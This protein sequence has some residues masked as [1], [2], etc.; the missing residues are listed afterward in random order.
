VEFGSYACS[1]GRYLIV[2]HKLDQ[3][4]H[5][6]SYPKTASFWPTPTR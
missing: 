1:V 5:R 4:D 2:Y 3:R 6:T